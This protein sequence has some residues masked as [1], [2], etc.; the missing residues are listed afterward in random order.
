M[1]NVNLP[2]TAVLI[3][4]D[5]W[6]GKPSEFEPAWLVS[7]RAMRDR[8]FAFQ[9][10]IT[11]YA[12]CYDK[13]PPQCLFWKKPSPEEVHYPLHK[14]QMWECLSGSVECWT[15]RQLID[16]P[17]LV[18]MGKG[19]KPAAGHYWFTLDYLP[20]GQSLGMVDI[21]DTELL[22]EHKEA[23]FV[24]LLNGQVAIYPNNR[25]KWMPL[26]LTPKG[27]AHLVPEWQVASNAQWDD[28]WDDSTEIL[29]DSG[30]AY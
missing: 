14:L 24:K 2:K 30:W 10:W 25:L 9:A 3:R 5:A 13:I 29:G 4:C 22:E 1:R 27:A 7:A 23:N 19:E 28:W 20:E 16:V 26:S 8:P 17:M 12:A 11:K 18:N 6:G 15:K 21:G